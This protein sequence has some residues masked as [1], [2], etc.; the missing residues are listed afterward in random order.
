[1]VKIEAPETGFEPVTIA[2]TG[3]RSAIELLGNSG[4]IVAKF[5]FKRKTQQ[6]LFIDAFTPP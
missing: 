4:Y 1:M 2:L 5:W 6:L 3:R